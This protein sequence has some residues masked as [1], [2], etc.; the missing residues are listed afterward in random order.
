[1]TKMG[2]L[3]IFAHMNLPDAKM[4]GAVYKSSGKFNPSLSIA[5]LI[6]AL[7]IAAIVVFLYG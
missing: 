6:V 1:M 7:I 5:G 2:G 3:F 4:P